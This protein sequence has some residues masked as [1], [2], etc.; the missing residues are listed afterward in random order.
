M[1][2]LILIS[3][4]LLAALWLG[5]C[6]AQRAQTPATSATVVNPVASTTTPVQAKTGAALGE[7]L[8]LRGTGE[9]GTQ[10]EFTGGSD[11]YKANP[12][13]CVGC[14]GENG[15]GRQTP[16]GRI[17]AITYAALRGGPKPDFPADAA[18][19]AAVREGKEPEGGS[20][21]PM[22]P[23]FKLTDNEAA[24]LLEYLKALDTMPVPD[25]LPPGA[26]APKA[27]S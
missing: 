22:M 5:G 21:A 19:I 13:G 25:K 17:P 15:K 10:V 20:L 14:H 4:A 6:P 23:R 16:K 3:A 26:P 7:D 11:R 18:V 12:G 1:K 24:G 8:F 9:S 27:K 2:T